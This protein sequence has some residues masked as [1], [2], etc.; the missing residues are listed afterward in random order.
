MKLV[1]AAAS[2]AGS[3]PAAVAREGSTSAPQQ[4]RGRRGKGRADIAILWEG[5][6]EEKTPRSARREGVGDR[7]SGPDDD[8]AGRPRILA[9]VVEVLA[10]LRERVRLRFA[11]RHA[12]V[13]EAFEELGGAVRERAAGRVHE[14]HRRA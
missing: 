10:R 12:Q 8:L 1:G 11:R 2:A 3:A 14:G 9:V 13:E 7:G 6:D 5:G 4:A